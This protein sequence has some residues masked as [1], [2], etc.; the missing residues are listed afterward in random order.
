[1]GKELNLDDVAATSTLAK[2]ELAA[3][4]QESADANAARHF[5]LR[6]VTDLRWALGDEGGRMQD[7]LIEYAKMLIK[8]ADL[9]A[10]TLDHP[11]TAAEVL[12]DAAAGDGTARENL[13]QRRAGLA[14]A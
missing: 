7:E 12:Q 11:E 3:L 5:A 1:M 13:E 9:L 4:R 6:L 2:T 10:W 8:D 14:S